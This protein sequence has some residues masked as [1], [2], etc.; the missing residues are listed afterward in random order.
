MQSCLHEK[1]GELCFEL[2]M[3]D[4]R[5]SLLCQVIIFH[6]SLLGGTRGTVPLVGIHDYVI[7]NIFKTTNCGTQ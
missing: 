7:F 5:L 6:D 4:S 3:K 1:D 2:I